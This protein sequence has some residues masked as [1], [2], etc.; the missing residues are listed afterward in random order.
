[1]PEIFVF[2]GC[3]GSGKTTLANNF[4]SSAPDI[5]YVNA[6]IIAARLNSSDVEAV[7]I[8][9][10]RIMLTRLNDLVA[11]EVDFAFET[12]HQAKLGKSSKTST[13]F[14]T[15]YSFQVTFSVRRFLP[16]S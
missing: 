7:A 6:D 14:G 10:S 8:Q 4:L 2:G 13:A 11:S 15:E 12:T 16:K 1:M 5:E 3:N 9:A